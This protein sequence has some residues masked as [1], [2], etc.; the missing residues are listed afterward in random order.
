MTRRTFREVTV[1]PARPAADPLLTL[2]RIL[3]MP[4]LKCL[5]RNKIEHASTM[6]RPTSGIWINLAAR[7]CAEAA[8]LQAIRHRRAAVP[9]RASKRTHADGILSLA[10]RGGIGELDHLRTR[11]GAS[12]RARRFEINRKSP[13]VRGGQRSARPTGVA[14]WNGQCPEPIWQ[15]ENT[16]YKAG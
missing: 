16:A 13:S 5:T 2:K 7:C 4:W 12:L 11:W 15:Q 14:G 9:G 1:H 8:G 3:T 6:D 10:N